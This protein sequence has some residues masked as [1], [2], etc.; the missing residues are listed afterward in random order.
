MM[1][2]RRRYDSHMG[3]AGLILSNVTRRASRM[4]Q[5]Y[6]GNDALIKFQHE[7]DHVPC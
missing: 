5:Y 1:A 6:G 4:A 3:I 7:D 2:P